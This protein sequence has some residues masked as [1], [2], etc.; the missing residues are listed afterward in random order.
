[1]KTIWK[2]DISDRTAR[3]PVGSKI[4]STGFQGG[5][6]MVWAEVDPANSM[7]TR[8]FIICVTGHNE[9][10]ESENETFIGTVFTN[11]LVFHIYDLGEQ[12]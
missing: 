4:L 9:G 2:F 3:M 6:L 7:I 8:R 11:N 1:M 5:R 10:E 12:K